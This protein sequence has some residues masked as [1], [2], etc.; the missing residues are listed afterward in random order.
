MSNVTGQPR[1]K[2][3]IHTH[4]LPMQ[5]PNWNEVFGGDGWITIVREANGETNMRNS[6]GSL[7]RKV[8]KNCFCPETRIEECDRD[9]VAIQVLSTVPGTGFNYN[10][11][12]DQALTV[13]KFLNDDIAQVVA[14]HSDRF[15]GM[16]T[17]G[18]GNLFIAKMLWCK[19]LCAQ[20]RC[21]TW[22]WQCWSC[23]APWRNCTWWGC[24]SGLTLWTRLSTTQSTNRS[25][26]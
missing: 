9:N 7:F 21:K 2:I 17:V 16:E 3:D 15:V 22:I 13:A 6:D 26:R 10:K 23:D 11:P 1:R 4:I 8:D 12:D 20:Y 5:C 25:G 24:R 18:V 19:Q 14:A